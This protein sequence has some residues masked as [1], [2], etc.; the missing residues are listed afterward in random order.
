MWLFGILI[1]ISCLV[2]GIFFAQYLTSV[3]C[4]F[5]ALISALIYWILGESRS[6]AG[7]LT[8]DGLEAGTR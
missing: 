8:A 5:A 2:S 3:W 1:T 7:L 6:R 4:F